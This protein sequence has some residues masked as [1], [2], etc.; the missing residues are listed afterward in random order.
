MNTIEQRRTGKALV[1]CDVLIHT[2]RI[3]GEEISKLLVKTMPLADSSVWLMHHVLPLVKACSWDV[4]KRS[5]AGSSNHLLPPCDSIKSYSYDRCDMVL[6]NKLHYPSALCA[7]GWRQRRY[8]T[9][10]TAERGCWSSRWRLGL[11]CSFL[12]RFFWLWSRAFLRREWLSRRRSWTTLKFE[13]GRYIQVASPGSSR[14]W[15]YLS[16]LPESAWSSAS[17]DRRSQHF[18]FTL[19]I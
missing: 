9:D 10:M 18:I 12:R 8:R 1:C 16:L 7:K 5:H 11:W 3:F 2:V 17:E 4:R 6:L 19:S 14:G 13:R 15:T